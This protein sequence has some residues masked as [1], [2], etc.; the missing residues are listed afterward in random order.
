MYQSEPGHN[1]VFA[2]PG[3]RANWLTRLGDKINGG[4]AVVDGTL[5]ADSS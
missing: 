4:L 5:Y 1:A 3:F 2:Q